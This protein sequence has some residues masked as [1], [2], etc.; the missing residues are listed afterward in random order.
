MRV[1]NDWNFLWEQGIE[2]LLFE[3]M[4]VWVGI[5]GRRKDKE[6][7]NVDNANAET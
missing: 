7:R 4:R 3:S 2:G 6:V 1:E 5:I